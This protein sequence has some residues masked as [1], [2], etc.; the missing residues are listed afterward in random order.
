M[1][2]KAKAPLDIIVLLQLQESSWALPRTSFLQI[3]DE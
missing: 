3:E 2:M 1:T